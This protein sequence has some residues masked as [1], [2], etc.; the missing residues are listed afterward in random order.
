VFII[1]I[2]LKSFGISLR[3]ENCPFVPLEKKHLSDILMAR[4][5]SEKGLLEKCKDRDY[6]ATA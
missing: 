2:S 3:K 6:I 5:S 1:S 4:E